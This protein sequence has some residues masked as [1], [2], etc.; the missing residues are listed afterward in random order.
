[1]FD[2]LPPRKGPEE[3]SQD[4]GD[5]TRK[6]RPSLSGR[7]ARPI[8][9]SVAS[10]Q[11]GSV[12]HTGPRVVQVDWKLPAR[13]RKPV[14]EQL[15]KERR[16]R[17]ERSSI[18]RFERKPIRTR[19]FLVAEN[20]GHGRRI[21]M[22][23]RRLF[24]RGAEHHTGDTYKHS[25]PQLH[26][27]TPPY[28]GRFTRR[29]VAAASTPRPASPAVRAD[30]AGGET[31]RV[32]KTAAKSIDQM[33]RGA[34][35]T[36]PARRADAPGIRRTPKRQQQGWYGERDIAF[37]WPQDTHAAAGSAPAEAKSDMFVEPV[38]AK[39]KRFLAL[40]FSLNIWPRFLGKP[41]NLHS[42]RGAQAQGEISDSAESELRLPGKKK[43]HASYTTTELMVL[44]VGCALA[45]FLVWNLQSMGRGF[46]VL[47]SVEGHSEQALAELLSAQAAL[48]TT[49]FA[50][51][52]ESFAQA[53]AQ[54]QA[55]R[56]ELDTALS[57]SR[58][59]LR[60]VDVTGTVR[61][62]QELLTAGELLT[63]VGQHVSRAVGPLLA[64]EAPVG[65]ALEASDDSGE[66]TLVD[67]I[68]TA[69][70]EMGQASE[71]LARVETGLAG[72][73]SPFLPDEIKAQVETLQTAVPRA[74]NIIDAIHRQ[75]GSYLHLLGAEHDRHYLVLFANNHELRPVGGFIGTIGLMNIDRGRV[76]NID[77]QSVY[78]PDGQLQEFIAPPDPLL[79]IVD[80]WYMRDAN[81][82]VDY[83]VS[84]RKIATFFEKEGGP[85]VDGVILLTP[86]VIK[87]L[88]AVT[89][90][91]NVPGYDVTVSA[92][93][94][95]EVT[96]AEVTYFYDKE[97]NRPKQFLADLTPLLLN[98]LFTSE[99]V[100]GKLEV[101]SAL[102]GAL[103]HKELLLYFRDEKAQA[104][105]KAAGWHGGYPQD[106]PG[107]LSVNNA[108][109][110]GHKSDQFVEQE[111][112]YRTQ[113]H[114]SGDVDVVL[115]IRREHKG[116]QEA[117]DIE[118]PPGEDPA[119]KD[120]ITY[121][122]V[123]VPK[124]AQLIEASGFSDIADVPRTQIADSD[125][126][127]SADADVALWQRSQRKHTSGTTVGEEAG[128]TFFANWMITKPGQTSVALYRYRIPAHVAM[129]TFFA[130]A[131][132][133]STYIAKQP[134]QIRTTVRSSLTLPGG[135]QFIHAVPE[136]GITREGDGSVIYRGNLA[137]DTFVGGVFE[138]SN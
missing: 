122:R 118:Y 70:D 13:L 44:A 39:P 90:P 28:V 40:P 89:G 24:N 61:S 54:L 97:E 29:T 48:A 125:V 101:V 77:V 7:Q 99:E 6:G 115:T 41:G 56:A 20:E 55:A 94:F 43:L 105:L 116:P 126:P 121:Q 131:Q 36:M 84:A 4:S 58:H 45:G 49:D 130:P 65:E 106:A 104:E 73:G 74:R 85:T 103:E 11:S 114:S 31:R 81:W 136:G 21:Q 100:A 91:I 72:I 107:F 23:K 128:Y 83:Q 95:V 129:P 26:V 30:Q 8:R 50:A 80:R 34:A 62:G 25:R 9:P 113:L 119:F 96:Q 117:L 135:Y 76:E 132:G 47:S 5:V 137:K 127:L 14:R 22:P 134:G 133:Y 27:A 110:G 112:D 1:M 51:S 37:T 60:Y 12:V 63:Q 10:N 88:L 68:R 87:R 71:K 78:D 98:T 69:Q 75:S 66:I 79:P 93:N 3:S 35:P 111:I 92:E 38:V 32:Q 18:I 123:L 42:L 109:I 138:R 57:A 17:R 16:A 82:F 33:R 59:I 15:A 108:N 52:E 46:A 19:P 64:A 86:D 53:E 124:G 120:N 102:T 67:A 2:V